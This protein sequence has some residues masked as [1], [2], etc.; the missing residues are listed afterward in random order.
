MAPHITL[1][2]IDDVRLAIEWG[3]GYRWTKTSY[4]NVTDPARAALF[5][6]HMSYNTTT[7]I[8]DDNDIM[9]VLLLIIT[10]MT[11][12]YCYTL[13]TIP[14]ITVQSMYNQCTILKIKTLVWQQHMPKYVIISTY[15]M[16]KTSFE[17]VYWINTQDTKCRAYN[18]HIL[19]KW[20]LWYMAL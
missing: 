14:T 19:S 20:T 2:I 11:G 17:T 8:M 9:I 15:T 6:T 1:L 3:A 18:C 7:L 5:A 4:T 10:W 13:F 16:S 12:C